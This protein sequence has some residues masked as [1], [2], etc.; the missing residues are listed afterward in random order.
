MSRLLWG[1]VF[2]AVIDTIWD[3]VRRPVDFII[4]IIKVAFQNRKK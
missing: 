2:I 1:L 4:H 3:W